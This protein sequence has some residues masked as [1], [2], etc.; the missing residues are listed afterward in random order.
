[1]GV[2][3]TVLLVVLV[4]LMVII[5]EI[6]ALSF[7]F[8]KAWLDLYDELS[9]EFITEEECVQRIEKSKSVNIQKFLQ[10]KFLF[11]FISMTAEDLLESM[12]DVVESIVHEYSVEELLERKYLYEH[13]DKE[14]KTN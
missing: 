4:I 2:L 5:S 14:Y 6:F 8:A 7:R 13:L 12:S 1:M 10:T 3:Y 11:F 9:F